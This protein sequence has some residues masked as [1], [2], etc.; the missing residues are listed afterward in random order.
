MQGIAN[1]SPLIRGQHKERPDLS[2]QH[3]DGK[4]NRESFALRHPAATTVF[5]G[6]QQLG[7]GNP[8]GRQRVLGH[9]IAHGPKVGHVI[10]G[11]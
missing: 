11:R 9:G 4:A 10:A 6:R 3:S 5:D 8:S 7:V 1:T 2:I